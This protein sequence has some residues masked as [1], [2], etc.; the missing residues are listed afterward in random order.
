MGNISRNNMQ[1]NISAWQEQ[2]IQQHI[3]RENSS[4]RQN[5]LQLDTCQ[6]LCMLAKILT[7]TAVTLHVSVNVLVGWGPILVSKSRSCVNE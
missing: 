2:Y 7:R 4:N 3:K 5:I 1:L 6:V